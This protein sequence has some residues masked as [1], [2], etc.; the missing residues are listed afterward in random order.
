MNNHSCL[1]LFDHGVDSYRS[2]QL[3]AES[4]D[5]LIVFS[6]IHLINHI[7]VSKVN[8]LVWNTFVE[9]VYKV[10][11]SHCILGCP[12]FQVHLENYTPTNIVT[13][14]KIDH[15]AYQTQKMASMR[16]LNQIMEYICVHRN[17]L[18]EAFDHLPNPTQI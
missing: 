3:L 16:W 13:G 15:Y 4:G 5:Y 1:H 6:D 9:G 12:S 18:M 17:A 14:Q 10:H 11:L 8:K 2:L 7:C